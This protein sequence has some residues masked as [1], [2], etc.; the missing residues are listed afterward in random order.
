MGSG[1]V[2]GLDH[3]SW[4]SDKQH[5]QAD[6]NIGTNGTTHQAKHFLPQ[7]SQQPY[8]VATVYQSQL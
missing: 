1:G 7:S 4:E 6:L 2:S 8:E 5:F 3:P